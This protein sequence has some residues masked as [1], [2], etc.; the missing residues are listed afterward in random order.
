MLILCVMITSSLLLSACQPST[1]QLSGEPSVIPAVETMESDEV[2]DVTEENEDNDQQ[3]NLGEQE[4]SVEIS[5][6]S[7]AQ[8]ENIAFKLALDSQGTIVQAQAIVLSEHPISKMRQTS[9]AKEFPKV[10]EGK[11]LADLTHV[12]RIGGSSLTTG[13]FNNAL[14]DLKSQI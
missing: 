14:E 1:D 9:F 5:Y 4:V 12:D 6:Q 7:P 10:L 13:A 2:R 3:D 11:K 8:L